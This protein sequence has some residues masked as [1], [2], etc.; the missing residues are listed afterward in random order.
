VAVPSGAATFACTS[1]VKHFFWAENYSGL[2]CLFSY[3]RALS[4]FLV[5]IRSVGDTYQSA[6]HRLIFSKPFDPD[7]TEVLLI[8]LNEQSFSPL[9][10]EL[11]TA[12]SELFWM[13]G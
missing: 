9:V 8:P 11:R 7:D 2:I 6:S 10:N 3:R 4:H 13:L 12:L 1:D 5:S